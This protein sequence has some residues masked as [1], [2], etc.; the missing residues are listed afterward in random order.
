VVAAMSLV[1]VETLFDRMAGEIARGRLESAGIAAVL[2]DGG[3]ASAIGSGV[4]GV[5]LMVDD[6]DEVAARALLA[7]L[8]GDAAA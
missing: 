7:D 4:S 6:A 1:V 3:I 2:F 5:R 8:E